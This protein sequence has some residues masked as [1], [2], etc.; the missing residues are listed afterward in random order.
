[1][2]I[3]CPFNSFLNDG[4]AIFP[5][6]EAVA[7]WIPVVNMLTHKPALVVCIFLLGL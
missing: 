4:V 1:M 5:V 3:D 2:K 7:D 6:E